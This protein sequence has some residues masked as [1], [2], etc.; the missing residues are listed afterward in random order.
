MDSNKT[1]EC[2]QLDQKKGVGISHNK[3]DF[4]LA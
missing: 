1:V 2:L 3:T 4:I